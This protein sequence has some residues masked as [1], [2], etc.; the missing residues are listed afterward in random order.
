MPDGHVTATHADRRG[1]DRNGMPERKA[2]VAAERAAFREPPEVTAARERHRALNAGIEQAQIALEA[3]LDEAA[4]K[5][6][7]QDGET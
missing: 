2:Y 5:A 7:E 6:R 3:R 1:A 4:R